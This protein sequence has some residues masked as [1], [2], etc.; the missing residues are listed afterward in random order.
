MKRVGSSETT[1]EEE[2]ARRYWLGSI[3]LALDNNDGFLAR[4]MHTMEQTIDALHEEHLHGD[5]AEAVE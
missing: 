4:N 3:E 5:H 2:V 1:S